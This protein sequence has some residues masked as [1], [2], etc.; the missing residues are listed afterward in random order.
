MEKVRKRVRTRD[1]IGLENYTYNTITSKNCRATAQKLV[2][3]PAAVKNWNKVSPVLKRRK[4]EFSR[5]PGEARLSLT[6]AP[7]SK[8][9]SQRQKKSLDI[10]LNSPSVPVV[11]L[12]QTVNPVLSRCPGVSVVTAPWFTRLPACCGS[13]PPFFFSPSPASPALPP[14]N[15]AGPV[16]PVPTLKTTLQ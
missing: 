6:N 9:N 14:H 7:N 15:P 11:D 8:Q 13:S 5:R 4:G 16:R 3:S 1:T 12:F 2:S 10:K